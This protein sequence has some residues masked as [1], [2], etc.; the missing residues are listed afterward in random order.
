MGTMISLD[1]G[2]FEI[3][4]GKNDY[5]EDYSFLFQ[6]KD[7][8][9]IKNIH[10]SDESDLIF[11]Y[12]NKLRFI[13]DRLDILGYT[14]NNLEKEYK[15]AI[16]SKYQ[17]EGFLTFQQLQFFINC[18]DVSEIVNK[19]FDWD[20][21]YGDISYGIGYLLNRKEFK[22]Y[23]PKGFRLKKFDE[24]S[25]NYLPR[26]LLLRLL[27]EKKENLDF[28]VNWRIGDTIE[29]GWVKWK[30]VKPLISDDRKICIITEGSSDTKLL[31]K[32]IDILK[33]HISDLF[34]FIDMQNNY[35]FTG[36]G[37]L[38]R[39]FKGLTKINIT[40]KMLFIFDNDTEGV[41]KLNEIKHI[42]TKLTN[43][44]C[45]HLPNMECFNSF[46]TE[47]P[48]GITMENIN[49][50]AVSIECFLD[51]KHDGD[52]PLIRWTNYSEKTGQYQGALI[53]K[54]HYLKKC[55]DANLKSN[56]YDT[57]KLSFLLDYIVEEIKK[58]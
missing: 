36:T 28:D 3:D 41:S 46:P 23:L 45:M 30:D 5:Y 21:M 17:L 51:L 33:P 49:G 53:K 57:S 15:K 22:K 52:T 19:G 31:N 13:R 38:T 9:K 29:S 56:K 2:N 42:K 32:A 43:L 7:R 6:I 39:F 58:Y 10:R 25:Y 37:E 44:R 16:T 20:S 50:R 11:G 47:G 4:Y 24:E 26:C 35:P 14:I 18:I 27:A 48:S 34:Y 12:T 54:D 55:T 1:V 8:K 40:N